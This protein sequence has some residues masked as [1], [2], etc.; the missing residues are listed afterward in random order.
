MKK[1]LG[2]ALAA[3]LSLSMVACGNN[4]TPPADKSKIGRA[5][6]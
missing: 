6:V 3:A 1:I 5:H 4:S 2:I